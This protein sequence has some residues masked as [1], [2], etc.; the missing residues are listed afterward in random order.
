[1]NDDESQC[2]QMA[3]LD[4]DCETLLNPQVYSNHLRY[5]KGIEGTLIE[6]GI[7]EVE[8]VESYDP[9]TGKYVKE[10]YSTDDDSASSF[11]GAGG[12]GSCTCN[13]VLRELD[14]TVLMK[15]LLAKPNASDD[16]ET[17]YEIQKIRANVVYQKTAVTSD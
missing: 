12:S 2:N 4:Q 5:L 1:M 8:S 17:F 3:R 6:A 10:A 11:A 7:V 13:K 15:P 9:D 14:Y 16:E